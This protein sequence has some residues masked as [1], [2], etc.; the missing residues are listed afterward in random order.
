GNTSTVQN[1]RCDTENNNAECGFDGGDCCLCTCSHGSYYDCG[2][3]GFTCLD[4]NV[5]GVEPSIYV[6]SPSTLISC[7]A[8]LQQEWIVENATQARAFASSSR[9]VGGS[10]NVTWRGN[11]VVDKTISIYE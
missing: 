3:N 6:E 10:L 4:P 11:I 1:G 9:C 5:A 7:P 2:S 8:E